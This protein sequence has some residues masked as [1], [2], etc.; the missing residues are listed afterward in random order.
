MKAQNEKAIITK[1][2]CGVKFEVIIDNRYARR[3]GTFKVAL[4]IYYGGK[5][6]YIN[7]G[8]YAATPA[9]IDKDNYS[10]LENLMNRTF[11]KCRPYIDED[12]FTVKSVDGIIGGMEKKD[13]K[14]INELIERRLERME[15]D[16]K[17]GT[18]R[19]WRGFA[20]SFNKAMGQMCLK[21]VNA[22]TMHK[23]AEYLKNN[24]S[25]TTQTFYLND[26]KA[27]INEAIYNK[28]LKESQNPFKV[29]RYDCD[30]NKIIVPKSAK[31]TDHYL[32][33]DEMRAIWEYNQTNPDYY[34]STF[35]LSYLL[36]GAN[37]A[38]LVNM[39]FDNHFFNTNEMEIAFTR[40]KTIEKND[41]MVRLAVTEKVKD[42]FKYMDVAIEK[43]GNILGE[44][45]IKKS[46]KNYHERN[47]LIN[48]YIKYHMNTLCKKIGINK[49]VSATWARHSFAT[50]ANRL[51]LPFAWIEYS[52]GHANNNISSHYMG[53][54]TTE[55]LHSFSSKL[56]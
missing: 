56:L 2:Y 24:Y 47:I 54:Y 26:L 52:M 31:R 30:P 11:Q 44:Q 55:Q 23:Y 37:V 8:V 19:T 15:K 14:T 48:A 50:I 22:V 5:Y 53:G 12:I 25:Q 42:L 32:T 39:K 49:N 21:D 3:D 33:R 46:A 40:Q 10:A 7:T 6:A 43:N 29:S 28:Y 36:G 27:V 20:T 4:R 38:D 9:D 17:F 51:Q 13:V 18:L 1:N 35:L 34:V 41:F 45:A 16:G